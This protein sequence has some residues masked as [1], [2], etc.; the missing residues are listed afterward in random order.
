M[1]L[2]AVVNG[3][4]SLISLSSVS[5]LVYRNAIDFCVLILYPDTSLNSCLTSSNFEGE[6]WVHFRWVHNLGFRVVCWRSVVRVGWRRGLIW[7]EDGGREE[8][9]RLQTLVT[10]TLRFARA[11]QDPRR[12]ERGFQPCARLEKAIVC[13]TDCVRQVQG[14]EVREGYRSLASWFSDVV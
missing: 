9:A 14:W 8:M 10:Q 3:I 7:A 2:G 12:Y 1:L 6:M 4:D 13:W 11:R 5:L